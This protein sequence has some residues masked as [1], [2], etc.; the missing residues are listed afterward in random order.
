MYA[1]EREVWQQNMKPHGRLINDCNSVW[2]SGNKS[3][4]LVNSILSAAALISVWVWV[5]V[6]G[7]AKCHMSLILNSP[8]SADDDSLPTSRNTETPQTRSITPQTTSHQSLPPSWPTIHHLPPHLQVLH[9]SS[10]RHSLRP[11]KSS[12][13]LCPEKHR[14]SPFLLPA[15]PNSIKTGKSCF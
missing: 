10:S 13:L 15:S 6:C 9:S 12:Q 8:H 14:V 4:L 5:W 1:C 3:L 11:F 7:E 2:T